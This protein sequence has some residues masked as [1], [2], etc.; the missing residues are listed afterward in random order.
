[1][2]TPPIH[3]KV[4]HITHVGNL[5]SIVADGHLLCDRAMIERGGPA[6]TIGISDIKRRRVEELEISCR[7]GTKVGDY[8]PFNFCPRSVMLF[9]IHCSN[10][11]DLDYRGGQEPVV[12]LEADLHEVV[13]WASTHSVSWALSLGNAGARFTEFRSQLADLGELNWA[14]IAASYW[15]PSDVKEAK[16]AEF[17]VQERFP[18]TLVR[19]IGVHSDEVSRQVAAALEP[20]SHKPPIAIRPDWYY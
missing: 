18:F 15:R 8:V 10:N 1:M 13:S 5:A 11:R 3:P 6:R 16:Q 14:A 19:R 2:T 9:V 7:P 17:L 4:Y 20:S 12:H